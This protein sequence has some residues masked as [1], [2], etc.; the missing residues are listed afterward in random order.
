MSAVIMKR[1]GIVGEFIGDAIM[2]WWNAPMDIGKYHT[3]FALDAAVSQQ[4]RLAEFRAEWREQGLP[5]V[6][7]RMGISRGTVYAGNIGSSLRMK[8]GLVGD[9]VN[10]TSRLEGL[11]KKYCVNIIIDRA[12]RDAPG[13]EEGFFCRPLD[14]VVVK[15]R[16]SCTEIFELVGRKPQ[17][18]FQAF[19]YEECQAFVDSFT[20]IQSKYRQ[21][22]F[23]GALR[24]LDIFQARW[25]GDRPAEILRERCEA[26]L[27]KPP[28][29]D[30]TPVE[31]LSHK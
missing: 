11:C 13:V 6:Y 14:L 21:R 3:V 24:C 31:S 20:S 16:T 4:R 30:W 23:Q 12:A 1:Q 19:N 25:P 22:D 17:L 10:L 18:A 27:A 9:K 28:S 7:A 8:Y 5:D 2:A 15:G 29:E 26:L